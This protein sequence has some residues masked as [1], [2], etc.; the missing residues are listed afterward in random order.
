MIYDCLTTFFYMGAVTLGGVSVVHKVCEFHH[1]FQAVRAK[2]ES[3]QWLVGQCK[4]PMFFSNMHSHTDLC[5]QVENN[6]RV[7]AFMMTMRQV[8]QDEVDYIF[9][10]AI[11]SRLL[12]FSWPAVALIALFVLLCPS[13]VFYGGRVVTRRWPA[14]TDGHFKDA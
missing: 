2:L 12:A 13:W 14:C 11:V 9:S 4:D 6:R 10:H 1:A 3:E 5:I 8:V 7:G